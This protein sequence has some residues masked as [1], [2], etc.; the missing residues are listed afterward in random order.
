MDKTDD[1]RDQE[2]PHRERLL[3]IAVHKG[4][5]IGPSMYETACGRRKPKGVET[6][7]ELRNTIQFLEHVA[8][9]NKGGRIL[10][11]CPLPLVCWECEEL[12]PADA[13]AT[14]DP[15]AWR[16]WLPPVR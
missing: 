9:V 13:V 6:W 8:A 10:L 2:L 4:S 16:A 7:V 15:P 5:R 3:D 11:V 1:Q 12:M 14:E